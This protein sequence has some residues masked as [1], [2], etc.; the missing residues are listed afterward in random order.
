[1]VL[2]TSKV[3]AL[4]AG[5]FAAS[6]SQAA[7]YDFDAE[8][9]NDLDTN[10]WSITENAPSPAHFGYVVANSAITFQKGPNHL[11]F[12]AGNSISASLK[13][14][15]IGGPIS[16]DF[17]ISIDYSGAYL[18]GNTFFIKL[19]TDSGSASYTG[20]EAVNGNNGKIYSYVSAATSSNSSFYDPVPNSLVDSGKLTIIRTGSTIA[21]WYNNT[22][23][24]T[25][26][27]NSANILGI[28]LGLT[29]D[30]TNNYGQVTFSNFAVNAVPEPA[31]LTLAL[32]AGA[33]LLLRR[34]K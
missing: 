11:T 13:M 25:A 19:L 31:S 9:T 32:A 29:S 3:L 8:P 7:I 18:N 26:P 10:L 6:V 20:G 1:M 21:F 23:Q 28:S 30:N 22:M 27:W 24:L 4:T 34:R 33:G 16:G 2:T 15:G 17:N 5:L 12:T 14:P